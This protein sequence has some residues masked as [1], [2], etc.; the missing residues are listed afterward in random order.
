MEFTQGK[1]S[2]I[3]K[4]AYANLKQFASFLNV[5]VPEQYTDQN[6]IIDL[7]GYS[8][9]DLDGLLL[10]LPL[11]D[12]HRGAAHSLVII[13]ASIDYDLIPDELIVVPTLQ[14]AEDIIEMEEIERDLGF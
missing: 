6:V 9:L 13:N 8:D 12:A 2:V 5:K 14:E 10:F 7:I 4:D 3:L 11:S 1:Q